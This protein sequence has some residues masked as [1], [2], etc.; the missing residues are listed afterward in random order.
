MTFLT[1]TRDESR[2]VVGNLTTGF[3]TKHQVKGE[4]ERKQ[5]GQALRAT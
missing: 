4:V 3:E 1:P 5:A 2:A